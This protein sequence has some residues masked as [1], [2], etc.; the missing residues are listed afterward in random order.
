MFHRLEDA[1]TSPALHCFSNFVET[2]FEATKNAFNCS[3][4]QDPSFI[5]SQQ[6]K[7][8]STWAH[9]LVL[10]LLASGHVALVAGHHEA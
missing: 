3:G 7:S 9:S 5:F 6:L 1:T 8:D 4:V 2:T 10:G